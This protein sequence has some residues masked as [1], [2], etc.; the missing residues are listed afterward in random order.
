MKVRELIEALQECDPDMD[1]A[2][3]DPEGTYPEGWDITEVSIVRLP[4]DPDYIWV[5]LG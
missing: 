1:V 3:A 5:Q 4:S 2:Y